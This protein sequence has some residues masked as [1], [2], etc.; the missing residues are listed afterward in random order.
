MKKQIIALLVIVFASANLFAQISKGDV[1][2]L[3]DYFGAEK[4]IVVKEYMELSSL[5]D[6][7]F[8]P[9]YHDYE[10][11]RLELGKERI[12]NVNEYVKNVVNVTEDKATELVNKN[13][14]LEMDFKKLQKK[15]YKTMAKKIGAVKAAQFYQFENYLNNIINLSVQES[16]PFVGELEQ[17]NSGIPKK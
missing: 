5:Q 10:Q 16:F 14:A 13:I 3:Q 15:Y 1:Q 17:K 2:I 8:W 9:I 11:A 12:A 6:S 4:T 7:L